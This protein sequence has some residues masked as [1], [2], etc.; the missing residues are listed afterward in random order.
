MQETEDYYRGLAQKM[1]NHRDNNK[2]GLVNSLDDLK[3]VPGL[4]NSALASLKQSYYA[5]PVVVKGLTSIGAVVGSDLRRRALYAIGFSFLGMLVYIGFRFKPIYG[6]AAVFAVL[7]DVTITIGLFALTRKEISLTVIAA[8][9]TLIGY[10]M[11][12]TIVIFDRARENLRILRKE[13][14]Y[15]ILNLSVNQ[16]LAR[17]IITDGFTFVAVLSLFLFGGEV[18]N[19]FAFALVVGII[20]GT[21]STIGIASPIVD[22]WYRFVDR[23]SKQKAA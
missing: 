11:N 9:L 21:Y 5:G 15:N 22:W 12:D 18:L 16:T 13:S 17:T 14:I 7:H 4:S 2:G 19:G 23:K 8:L 3:S 10:S 1:K 6:V 20:I